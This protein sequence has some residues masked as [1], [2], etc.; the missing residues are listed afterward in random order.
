MESLEGLV[1]AG[2]AWE[3]ETTPDPQS[4][5]HGLVSGSF[6]RSLLSSGQASCPHLFGALWS[7]L[8][9]RWGEISDCGGAAAWSPWLSSGAPMTP[10]PFLCPVPGSLPLKWEPSSCRRTR[11]IL[12]LGHC[13]YSFQTGVIA[14]MCNSNSK[15]YYK[16]EGYCAQCYA[17]T[18]SSPHSSPQGRGPRGI[19]TVTFLIL[20]S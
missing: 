9:V 14:L 13:H 11:G 3:H 19:V 15:S 10:S 4:R 17:Y 8:E 5:H 2:G 20:Q 7:S 18:T 6:Q 12:P 16:K 1:C